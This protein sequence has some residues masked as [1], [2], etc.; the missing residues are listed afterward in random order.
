MAFPFYSMTELLFIAPIEKKD[1][2]KPTWRG[3]P[4]V[5]L[6]RPAVAAAI[7]PKVAP[8]A[9]EVEKK[10]RES[11]TVGTIVII[12]D[13]EFKGNRAVVIGENG[14]GL[15]KVNGPAIKPIEID[16]D[17]LIATSTKLEIGKVD[18]ASS[19]AAIDAA[20]QKIPEMTEYLKAKFS[21]KSGDRPHLMKF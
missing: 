3:I 17:Y 2:T 11:I 7:D 20:A 18:E 4:R 12:L 21:L 19:A 8:V 6:T 1:I 14:K 16:Q 9:K 10:T 13:G 5:S 15:V